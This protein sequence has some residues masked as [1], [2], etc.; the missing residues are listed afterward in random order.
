MMR[1]ACH[2]LLDIHLGQW[3]RFE[4]LCNNL[5]SGDT[6]KWGADDALSCQAG[7]VGVLEKNIDCQLVT[8]KV[9]AET[10]P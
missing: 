4:L 8:F 9:N 3:L 2:V 1:A 6:K 5:E 7:P 10:E